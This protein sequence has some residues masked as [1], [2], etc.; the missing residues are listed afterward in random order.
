[1]KYLI[2]ITYFIY[3]IL[4]L[5]CLPSCFMKK[6]PITFGTILSLTGPLDPSFD[7]NEVRDSKIKNM[8][9]KYLDK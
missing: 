1:M 5:F 8:Q 2:N 4:I 7:G 3:I 9:I 6:E